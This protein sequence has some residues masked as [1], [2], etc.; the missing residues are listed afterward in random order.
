[1]GWCQQVYKR[2]RDDYTASEVLGDEEYPAVRQSMQVSLYPPY[3]GL[4]QAFITRPLPFMLHSTYDGTPKPWFL[5]QKTGNTAPKVE[6]TRITKIEL[7][8]R[9]SLPS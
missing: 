9:P 3:R 2:C 6:P 7:I 8:R 4:G 1:M 5:A